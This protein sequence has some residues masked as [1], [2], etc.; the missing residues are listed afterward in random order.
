MLSC[1][2]LSLHRER[3]LSQRI[4]ITGA[5]GQL[6]RELAA[7]LPADCEGRFLDRAALD[8]GDLDAVLAELDRQSPDIVINAAAYTAVDRAEQERD[9]AQRVNADG[10]ANLARGCASVGAR[11]L[12]VSTDFVFDGRRGSPYR[13]EDD[14]APLSV[15]GHSKLLGEQQARAA[16]ADTLILRTGWVYSR[17]GA[18]FVRT[19]LR[20]MRE[21]EEL[22]VVDDQIGTP[23]WARDLARACWAVALHAAPASTWHWSDAGA[24]SW[25]DFACAIAE[26]SLA[27]DLLSRAPTI[28]PIGTA[29]YP[30]AAARPAYS[31]LDKHRSWQ[32]LPL[33][34]RHWRS[35]LRQMLIQIKESPD[36]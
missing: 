31:V 19:M 2:R 23:T 24:C 9:A 27:L 17:F 21:R 33:A 28:N 14:T 8:I 12:Q 18:N 1:A 10:P 3:I 16:L 7:T 36:E 5:N 25:Y 11:L 15:Y 26:E 34:P 32:Q 30:T 29:D 20:V 6:G 22:G 35:Q 13:P 4:L